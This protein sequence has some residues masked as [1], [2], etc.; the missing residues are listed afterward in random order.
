MCFAAFAITTGL[1]QLT[2]G[3]GINTNFDFS[4]VNGKLHYQA[5]DAWSGQGSFTLFFNDGSPWMIDFDLH[6]LA[7]RG[8][9]S[10]EV[11]FSALGGAH[12]VKGFGGVN[13]DTE[14]GLNL[15]GNITFPVSDKLRVFLEPKVTIISTGDFYIAAGVYF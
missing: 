14:L 7:L 12:L 5:N 8:G 1:G 9:Q 2:V 4:G 13:N 3:A 6:Y 15:G 10:D 11:T